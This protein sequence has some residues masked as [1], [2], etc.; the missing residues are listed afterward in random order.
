MSSSFE[1][2]GL[3]TGIS[4]ADVSGF[5]VSTAEGA[6]ERVFVICCPELHAGKTK[7]YIKQ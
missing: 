5:R 3:I 4:P 7:Q 1:V 2:S 6:F